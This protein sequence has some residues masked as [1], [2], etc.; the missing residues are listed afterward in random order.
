M[1]LLK[2]NLLVSNEAIITYSLELCYIILEFY[3]LVIIQ[4]N[5]LGA[6]VSYVVYISKMN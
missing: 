4:L 3:K 6:Y 2:N 5:I 1:V